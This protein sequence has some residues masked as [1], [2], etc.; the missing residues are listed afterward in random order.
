MKPRDPGDMHLP[1]LM[2]EV[3]R[4]PWGL[5]IDDRRT[6]IDTARI[7]SPLYDRV[8]TLRERLERDPLWQQL[9]SVPTD[10]QLTPQQR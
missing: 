4:L 6:P 1:L 9:R 5:S 3:G 8:T 7:N 10:E 2:Y